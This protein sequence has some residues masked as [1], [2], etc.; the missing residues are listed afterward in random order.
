MRVHMMI[1]AILLTP[2]VA[3]AQAT[4]GA[5]AGMTAAAGAHAST[6]IPSNFTAAGRAQLKATYARARQEHVPEAV[7]ASRVAEGEAKHASE[8]A[9]VTS[10]AKVETNMESARGAM[11]AAGRHPTDD[12]VRASAYAMDRG[13]TKAQIV[14][15]ARRTPSDRS[16]AV[17]F[18]AVTGLNQNGVQLNRALTEVQAKL[19]A[20]ASDAAITSLVTQAKAG[21]KLGGG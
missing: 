20:H 17:A 15:M 12:E 14:A 18:D 9:V 19:D 7:I 8:R 6:P 16:L 21:V 13:V 5:Q 3:Y 2:V 1:A 10:A 4:S 11:M